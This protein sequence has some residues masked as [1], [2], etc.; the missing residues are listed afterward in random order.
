MKSLENLLFNIDIPTGQPYQGA[1]LVSEPFLKEDYFDHSVIYLIEYDEKD[2]AMGVVMNHRIP[3]S[4]QEIIEGIER[5]GRIPVYCGGPMSR[6]RLFF[7]HA[8]GDIIPDSREVRDGLYVSGNFKIVKEYI[9]S[10]SPIDG[11]IRFFVGYSGW[12]KEQLVNE[13]ENRVWAVAENKEPENLLKGYGDS[14]WHRYV[15]TMGEKYRGWLYH[16]RNIH[17]N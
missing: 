17:A 7:V 3:F 15:R 5:R 14:Y 2:T 10:N 13:I 9:N 12:G 16:P 6:D 4:L 8:L 11:K 1:L